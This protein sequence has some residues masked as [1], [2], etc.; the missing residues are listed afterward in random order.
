MARGGR[1]PHNR[2]CLS[3]SRKLRLLL[4]RSKQRRL[5]TPKHLHSCLPL[6]PRLKVAPAVLAA[7]AEVD[8]VAAALAKVVLQ[9]ERDRRREMSRVHLWRRPSKCCSFTSYVFTL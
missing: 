4:R 9:E 7:E 2:E 5:R 1:K 3:H 8:S 6:G